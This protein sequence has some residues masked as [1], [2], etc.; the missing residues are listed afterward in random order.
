[1][2][3]K[4][5]KYYFDNEAIK[6]LSKYPDDDRKARAHKDHKSMPSEAHG[7]VRPGS[8]TYPMRNKRDVWTVTTKPYK[9]AH[10]ATFP[11]DLIRPCV[12]AGCPVGG[13]VMDPFMGAGTTAVVAKQE[14]RN[15]VGFELNTEYIKIAEKRITE[16]QPTPIPEPTLFSELKDNPALI[17]G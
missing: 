17:K 6:E 4:G 2:L 8:A 5:P 7:G 1:M 14:G 13:L 3:S 15:Y 12:L 10:F 9:E 11:P 16:T